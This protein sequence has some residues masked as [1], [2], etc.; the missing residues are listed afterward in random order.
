[1]NATSNGR[2]NLPKQDLGREFDQLVRHFFQDGSKRSTTSDRSATTPWMSVGYPAWEVIES[3]QGYRV[4]MDLPGFSL[5]EVSLEFKQG[6]LTVSA[7][8]TA[9]EVGEGETLHVQERRFGKFQRVL[10]F[11]DPVEQ[12]QIEARFHNGVLTLTIPKAKQAVSKKI[13]IQASGS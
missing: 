10:E 3:S 6:Q 2:W 9:S 4:S 12:D 11:H 1:M 8:R 7:S 13:E 5:E